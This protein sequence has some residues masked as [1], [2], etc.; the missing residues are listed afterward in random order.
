MGYGFI[1][2]K[3][4]QNTLFDKLPQGK[5]SI[6]GFLSLFSHKILTMLQPPRI[7]IDDKIPYIKGLAE[8]LGQCIY[9]PGHA[10]TS[11]EVRDADVLIVR[12]RTRCDES[13]LRHSRVRFIATATIGYDHLDTA[14]LEASGIGWTNCPGCNASSVAGYV[15]SAL[16]LLAQAGKIDLSRSTIGVVGVGHVGSLVAARAAALG[17]SVLRHDPPRA[18]AEGGYFVSLATLQEQADIITLHT[19]L[20]HTGED[21]TY[22]LIN[23][24]FFAGM[25]HPCVLINTSRGE[26][27]DTSALLQ[28]MD[29]ERVR[30]AVIDTWENEPNVS[31]QLLERAFLATPHI[32]GYSADGKAHAT[33]MVLQAVAHFLGRDDLTFDVKPPQL[34][35]PAEEIPSDPLERCLKLYDPRR[36]SDALRAAPHRFEAL[37]SSYPIRRETFL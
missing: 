19:P 30:A 9:L 15:E 24:P 33:Q 12:T 26:V 4:V 18:R 36:D 25:K 11:A 34:H 8:S 27:V 35:I 32:A 16:I 1:Y 13:L 21:A 31:P 7:I 10:I 2:A 5:C 17:L 29:E 37:R 6:F 22:H 23:T 20:T 28:A 14:F 3:V